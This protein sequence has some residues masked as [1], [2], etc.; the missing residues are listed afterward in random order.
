[1]KP[2]VQDFVRIIGIVVAFIGAL[3][4]FQLALPYFQ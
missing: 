4:V 2:F 3:L 1:M